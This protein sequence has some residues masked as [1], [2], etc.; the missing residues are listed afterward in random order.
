MDYVAQDDSA[1]YYV[2]LRASDTLL[3]EAKKECKKYDSSDETKYKISGNA[4]ASKIAEKLKAR[5]KYWNVDAKCK[6]V[7]LGLAI[8]YK[9]GDT[10]VVAVYTKGPSGHGAS[11]ER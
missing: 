6:H 11:I 9:G 7:N 3:S 5:L 8:L 2:P 10:Y 1:E 4:S